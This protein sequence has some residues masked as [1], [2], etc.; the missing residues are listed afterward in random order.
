M[1]SNNYVI[2]SPMGLHARPATEL[3]RTIKKFKSA[4]TLKAGEKSSL[5]KGILSILTLSAQS[6][7]EISVTIEGEDENEASKALDEFFKVKIKEL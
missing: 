6:G 7:D 2:L 4:V 5:V 3:L 1:I